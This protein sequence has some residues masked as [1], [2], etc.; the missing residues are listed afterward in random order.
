[1]QT[2][3][4]VLW[5][6]VFLSNTNNFMVSSNNFFLIIIVYLHLVIWFQVTN[7]YN[8][9]ESHIVSANVLDFDPGWAS[10]NNNCL[11]TG[12]T[13]ALNNPWR[14]IQYLAKEIKL[15]YYP[16][17][18]PVGWAC[19][20]HRLPQCK[21]VRPLNECPRYDTEQSEGEV[22]VILECRW[23]WSTSYCHRSQVHSGPEW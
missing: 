18:C 13:L 7:S 3:C 21:W 2:D 9:G 15:N 17:I 12:M 14:L 5:F 8:L 6:H 1:M 4:M 23:M 20:I 16:L 19:R 11:S 10:L 22:P